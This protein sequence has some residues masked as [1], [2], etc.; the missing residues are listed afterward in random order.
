MQHMATET[1]MTQCFRTELNNTDTDETVSN[2]TCY[3]MKVIKSA[4]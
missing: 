2:I 1:P 4:L 3:D